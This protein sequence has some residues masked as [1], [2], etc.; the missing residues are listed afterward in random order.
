MKPKVKKRLPILIATNFLA[1][2]TVVFFILSTIY[3]ENLLLHII[4]QASLS[5]VI[6]CIAIHAFIIRKQ[7]LLGYFL[8][9]AFALSLYS[10]IDPIYI[11]FKIGAF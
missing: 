7:K 2:T 1:V 9:G 3:A 4:S 8:I 6:L 11:G 10:V 5:S